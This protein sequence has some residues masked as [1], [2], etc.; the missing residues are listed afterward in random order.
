MED[1]LPKETALALTA[2]RLAFAESHSN[3]PSPLRR[4]GRRQQAASDA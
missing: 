4:R 3:D 2:P 1:P